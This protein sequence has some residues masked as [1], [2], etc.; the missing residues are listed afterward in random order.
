MNEDPYD[1][2][3]HLQFTLRPVG[4][5]RSPY[6]VHAGTPRQPAASAETGGEEEGRIVLKRGLQNLLQDLR[7][8]SHVWVLF[9]FH[10]SRGWNHTV[11]PPRDTEFRGLYA[12][13]SPHRPNAIGLSLVELKNVQGRTLTIGAHDILDGSPILDIKP[14]V[15][16]ADSAPDA[17]AGWVD[18]V[19]AAPDRASR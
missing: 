4:V 9:W 14:Y 19:D 17:R 7:G 13:R 6:R 18:D 5:M 10:H 1:L 2:P 11:K 15:P 16:Y 8:F 3:E 12:T